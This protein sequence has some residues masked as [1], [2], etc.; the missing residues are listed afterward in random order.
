MIYRSY[1]K[2]LW[3]TVASYSVI[4]TSI[5]GLFLY[6]SRAQ[7]QDTQQKDNILYA[8]AAQE[9]QRLPLRVKGHTVTRNSKEVLARNQES[10]ILSHKAGAVA[11]GL[12]VRVETAFEWIN[13]GQK[14][15]SRQ[16]VTL[17][18]NTASSYTLK[19]GWSSQRMWSGKQSTIL[20]SQ[21]DKDEPVNVVITPADLED[22]LMERAE[23]AKSGADLLL[24]AYNGQSWSEFLKDKDLQISESKWKNI[25]CTLLTWNMKEFGG[26]FTIYI[27][28]SRSFT[29]VRKEITGVNNRLVSESEVKDF[30][31]IGNQWIP[32]Q[33]QTLF[34]DNT[35]NQGSRQIS[36]ITSNA[37]QIQVAVTLPEH[38]FDLAIDQLPKGSKIKDIG[39]RTVQNIGAEV[40]DE[41]V[42]KLSNALQLFMQNKASRQVINKTLP[43][44]KKVSFPRNCGPYSLLVMCQ[45]L[46]IETT[47]KEMTKLAD[48]D[49][50]GITSM[51]GLV[52]ALN[53][54]GVNAKAVEMDLQDLRTV[55]LPAIL[56]L[57]Q[58]HYLVL[59][60]FG[61]ANV[62]VLDPPTRVFVA[63]PEQ[64]SSVWSKR[65]VVISNAKF[66]S[67]KNGGANVKS[68][69]SP[70][71]I[72]SFTM[73]PPVEADP[74]A[75]VATAF[76]KIKA[77][78]LAPNFS[79][80]DMNGQLRHLSDLRGKKNLLL[81]FF[82]R[83]FT[84]GCAGQLASLRD[85]QK[86]FASANTEVWAVSV[87]P[88]EG[89]KGQR[90]FA[91]LLN[92]NFPLLPD[93]ERKVSLLYGA[94][95]SQDQLAARMSILI[96]KE[97]IV[98][99]VDTNINIRT[100]GTE[101]LDKMRIL[102]MAK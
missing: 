50:Q 53:A 96:D 8:I 17:P 44:S 46:G 102:G 35:S 83:C 67:P 99:L 26:N 27:V 63:T 90:A 98:Q 47:S 20:N 68:S 11:P 69:D 34:Y 52:K 25:P 37:E 80:M 5:M 19:G 101:I 30:E 15:L 49:S 3:K 86:S 72:D 7:G 59:L 9:K 75:V 39:A 92:L 94:V 23:V 22:S 100:H 66:Q 82:P 64:I 87:D 4:I 10:W 18:I 84:G 33:V 21:N 57:T 13:A 71:N 60:K 16:R 24:C 28:P 97:G 65:A 61:E 12:L 62:F 40:S 2:G 42:I 76:P 41:D 45:M 88:A 6:S 14:Q 55:P 74:T 36:S 89:E 38:T 58:E 51:A 54:K 48:T 93:P 1:T 85:T 81:T 73:L 32:K 79:V 78:Q 70:S 95:Q 91:K 56:H 29:V 31:Q 77:G 43:D